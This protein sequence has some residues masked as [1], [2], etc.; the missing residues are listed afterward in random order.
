MGLESGLAEGL[1]PEREGL[2]VSI[3][4]LKPMQ[5]ID[6]CM[7]NPIKDQLLAVITSEDNM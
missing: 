7:Y 5:N 1:A 3:D 2:D 6:V 4:V